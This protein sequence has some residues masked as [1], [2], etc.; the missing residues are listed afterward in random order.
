MTTPLNH[1]EAA[2]RIREL[3]TVDG[4]RNDD[5]PMARAAPEVAERRSRRGFYSV[6]AALLLAA[7]GVVYL[8]VTTVPQGDLDEAEARI[9]ALEA[10]A[11]AAEQAAA[12]AA[13][14]AADSIA[15][16]GDEVA[17][18]EGTLAETNDELSGTVGTLAEVR[19]DVERLE[20]E[21]TDASA[22]LVDAESAISDARSGAVALRSAVGLR[23]AWQAWLTTDDVF[24]DIENRDVDVSG[25]DEALQT[26]GLGET[27][28][29]WSTTNFFSAARQMEDLVDQIDDLAVTEAWDAWFECSTMRACGDAGLQFDSALLRAIDEAMAAVREPLGYSEADF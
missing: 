28:E 21:V 22:A 20:G 29:E 25:I 12:D 10:E 14:E 6:L 24:D 13:R 2:D 1:T 3:P 11:S 5:T 23:L 15:A 19:A 4:S 16:L 18:L 27:W 17:A 26:L 8:V 9:V 7:A